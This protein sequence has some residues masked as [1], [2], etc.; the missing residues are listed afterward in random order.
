[1]YVYDRATYNALIGLGVSIKGGLHK[2]HGTECVGL[3]LV[4]M[5]P[6][7]KN[8]SCHMKKF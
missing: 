4:R 7:Q 2:Q 6:H 1:M 3:W 5:G 8:V